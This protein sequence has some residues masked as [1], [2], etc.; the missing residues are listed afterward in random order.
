M[1]SQSNHKITQSPSQKNSYRLTASSITY[2]S[3]HHEHV[4]KPSGL[5]RYTS[6]SVEPY[7]GQCIL[8]QT[9]TV[10]NSCREAK[11]YQ[12]VE[13][14]SRPLTANVFRCKL[15][16]LLIH[17]HGVLTKCYIA[18]PHLNPVIQVTCPTHPCHIYGIL[19]AGARV[20][21]P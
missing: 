9:Q 12:T 16:L 14:Y 2:L 11:R 20:T 3:L 10:T 17:C 4:A 19:D 15:K 18:P 8:K 6:I 5:R 13:Q 21:V 1:I 7:S